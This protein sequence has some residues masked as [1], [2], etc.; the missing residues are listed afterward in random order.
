MTALLL[1]GELHPSMPVFVAFAT[2][3]SWFWEAPRV[4]PNR[5]SLVWNVLTIIVLGKT[6]ADIALGESVLM[7]AIDFV[8]FLGI[9]KLFNRWRSNDYQQ[10]YVVSLLQMIAATT[11]ST[12]P[13]F[14]LLF[15]VYVIAITW[16][17]I[18][19][20][21]K[22]EMEGNLLL[23]YGESLEAIP[24]KVDRTLNSTRLVGPR[25]LIVTSGVSL[26]IF[27]GAALFFFLFPRIGFRLFQQTRA[28]IVMAGFNDQVQL[29]QFGLIKDNPTVVMRVEFD[30]KNARDLV[31]PY[32]RGIAFDTYDGKR[33]FKSVLRPKTTLARYGREVL[34]NRRFNGNGA[35]AVQHIYLDPMEQRVIFG[36][37]RIIRL[38][39]PVSNAA[40]PRRHRAIQRDVYG[41][42][43]YEQL[44][45]IAFK[46]TVESQRPKIPG[47]LL[48]M[49][50]E[51]Y[52]SEQQKLA[53]RG[54]APY[55]QLPKQLP[56]KI[57][58]LARPIVGD[59]STV[60]GAVDR[61]ER[62]LKLNYD[63]TLNLKRRDGLSPLQDFLFEQKRGHC[64]YFATAMV[65]L[66]RSVGIG[67]RL[68]NGFH[69]GEWNDYGGYLAV[70]QG[71]AHSWV[72]VKLSEEDCTDKPCSWSNRWWTRDPTP[73]AAT[74]PKTSG[75]LDRFR[76]YADA[77]RM[78][79][80]KY[81]IEYDLEQQVGFL[82]ALR[83]TWR[84]LGKPA[85]S[86]TKHQGESRRRTI[87]VVAILLGVILIVAFAYRVRRRRLGGG[88]SASVPPATLA[89]V[90]LV[91]EL[92]KVYY[93]QGFERPQHQT[94]RE[95]LTI[96]EA[97]G[98][99]GAPVARRII[100]QYECLRF[101]GNVLPKTDISLLRKELRQIEF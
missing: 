74:G 27:A 4:N 56:P 71:N 55:L 45:E 82:A 43:F 77:F 23:K 63:Y 75:L 2:L 92:L 15:I 35:K 101:G 30:K 64:E 17:L 38:E 90:K 6:L 31:P 57:R 49:P 26:L 25:F 61:I 46:Y 21:L 60:S 58:E 68:V 76:Q 12:D 98:A 11:L 85:A 86:L 48:K 32:W 96:L 97:G 87:R 8:L 62:H 39:L 79:W 20:H 3:C 36:L 47:S 89:I 67:A 83:E 41:D 37:D 80:Y 94:L 16:T 22:R 84:S 5:Y 40:L 73:A 50:L 88:P 34:L 54:Y 93:R 1:P 91:E 69:G 53:E 44:D 81:V 42:L 78:R 72:E 29:G 24:V 65:V 66:L 99:A 19:F 70:T 95:F 10:L 9:N 13:V 51:A 18:L 28:G 33:W 7:N 59:A 14:G 52:R 100:S